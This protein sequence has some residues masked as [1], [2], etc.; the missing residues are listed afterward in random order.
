MGI[1][2]GPMICVAVTRIK[3]E[4]DIIEAFVRHHAHYFDAILISDDGSTDST[5]EILRL[6]QSEGL[7]LIVFDE[8]W[9]GFEQSRFMTSL[10]HKAFNEFGADWVAPLDA[11]EFIEL[12]E[13][14]VLADALPKGSDH[15]VEIPWS[16]F[17]WSPAENRSDEINP[18][19][20][21]RW[22]M[23]SGQAM[24]KVLVPAT[25]GRDDS[26]A[27]WT[28]SHGLNR[29]SIPVSAIACDQISLCHYP[30]RSVA[31]FARKVIVTHLQ[32]TTYFGPNSGVGFQ[33]EEP[34]KLLKSGRDGDFPESMEA[35][36]R[37]YSLRPDA[38]PAD[39]EPSLAPLRYLG[40]PLQF[41]PAGG[42]FL[43]QTLEYAGRLA[44][45]AFAVAQELKEFRAEAADRLAGVASEIDSLNR[46]L[47][48]TCGVHASEREAMKRNSLQLDSAIAKMTARAL[49]MTEKASELEQ[50]LEEA[51]ARSARLQ[52]ELDTTKAAYVD[53]M[54]QLTH[55]SAVLS[56]PFKLLLTR[57]RCIWQLNSRG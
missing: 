5:R 31:Q 45:R 56:L 12:A 29:G 41:T 37:R 17:V 30:V 52:S 19:V 21:M 49:A 40:G 20:R 27:L 47:A 55:F 53:Q 26:A 18:V 23:P 46:E 14:K 24:T 3:N 10:M 2:E 13:S 8:P 57:V 32:F 25:I 51:R 35:Q 4:E 9:V 7:P 38:I 16:N 43:P 36:S 34:F 42:A 54:R 39:E 44:E 28:G 15:L 22:R 11:D 6:L 48:S 33:Y 50:A 1:A